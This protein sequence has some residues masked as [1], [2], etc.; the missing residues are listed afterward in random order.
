MNTLRTSDLT[1]ILITHPD[2]HRYYLG[3]FAADTIPDKPTPLTCFI[4]ITDP[5]SEPG[6][7]WVAFFVNQNGYTYYFD[8]Y[9]NPP[10]NIKHLRFCEKSSQGYWTYNRQRLHN[11]TSSNCGFHCVGFI[12]ETCR[13]LDPFTALSV[14]KSTPTNLTD[15]AIRSKYRYHHH[16]HVHFQGGHSSQSESDEEEQAEEMEREAEK[17]LDTTESDESY[18]IDLPR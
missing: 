5:Q 13:T 18:S 2:S 11:L 3:T 9:G 12:I 15:T 16:R 8:S 14:M 1:S 17:K 4:S 7:H 10:I 6:E